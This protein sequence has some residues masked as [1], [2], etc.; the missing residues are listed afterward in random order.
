MNLKTANAKNCADFGSIR[1]PAYTCV[2]PYP[3]HP[4]FYIDNIMDSYLYILSPFSLDKPIP[5]TTIFCLQN[6]KRKF[7]V[8]I[9]APYYFTIW[10]SNFLCAL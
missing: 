8:S 1:V 5:K 2:L 4:N 9:F 6:C 3:K 10:E 7:T